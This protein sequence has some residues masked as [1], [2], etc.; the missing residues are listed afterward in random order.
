[1]KQLKLKRKKI[2]KTKTKTKRR[3]WIN[4]LSDL[5]LIGM[6][7][8]SIGGKFG[9]AFFFVLLLLAI[10]LGFI[11]KSVV[12]VENEVNA[13]ERRGS[14]AIAITEIGSEIRAKSMSALS[15][16][17]NGS[18]VYID[19]YKEDQEKVKE[20]LSTIQKNVDTDQQ[21]SL[22]ESINTFND[23]IDEL[24]LEEIA[25]KYEAESNLF[26]FYTKQFSDLTNESL[27]Y[28]EMLRNTVNDEREEAVSNV[29]DSQNSVLI[30]L[31]MSMFLSIVIGIIMIIFLSRHV[32]KHLGKVV[33]MSNNI[34]NGDL[35]TDSL[36]YQ[37]KDEISRLGES[38]NVM[39]ENIKHIVQR[40]NKTADTV[41]KQSEALTQSSSEVKNGS[42]Q[43]A[44]TMEELASGTE[45]QASHAGD[46]AHAM[47][48][49]TSKITEASHNGK[50]VSQTTM[51]VGTETETGYKLMEESIKQMGNVDTIV[52]QAVEKV[53]GLDIQSREITKLISVIKDIAEQTNLLSLNAA[54]EAARAGEQGKG[55]AVVADEVRKLSEQV[56]DSV[57]DITTIAANIQKESSVVSTTLEEGYQEVA[58]G[59]EQISNTGA[60][61]NSI[62]D[63]IETVTLNVQ[64]M[65]DGL[66]KMTVDSEQM[67]TS[68]H[69]IASI[70]EQSAA[71]VEETTASAEETTSAM[72]EI[73][74]GSSQLA[75]SAEELNNLVRKF[76]Y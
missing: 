55:F 36:D 49:F 56:S 24:F 7:S 33:E 31:T 29:I 63:A 70:S 2:S 53:R 23:R 18:N 39:Q 71:G 75:L 9:T 54:I 8:K 5:P 12:T 59:K 72:E 46:L 14:R 10:S 73:T 50:K 69:E 30:T 17:Q 26:A 20:L 3:E 41:S 51:E 66:T 45:T 6:R 61:F 42:E 16:S 52:K 25:G 64:Q 67:N 27:S 65:T 44:A 1:M 13:L 38:M 74:T 76:K 58:R 35:T 48:N 60:S 21:K 40:I 22:M 19:E 57:K 37:A 43:I 68:I 62:K 28:L 47:E 15:Y 34:A 11:I 4:K 32:S